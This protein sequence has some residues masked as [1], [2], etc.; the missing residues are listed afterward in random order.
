MSDFYKGDTVEYS[1]T[2]TDAQG[3]PSALGV[4]LIEKDNTDDA[5]KAF[6]QHPLREFYTPGYY[7]NM[8]RVRMR[9]EHLKPNSGEYEVLQ[10]K[11]CSICFSYW[12]S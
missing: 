6:E 9:E 4:R 11:E 2:F 10:K 7:R 12:S 8:D 3:R 5:D 1:S